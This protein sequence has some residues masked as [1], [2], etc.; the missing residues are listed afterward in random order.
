MAEAGNTG[1]SRI[2]GDLLLKELLVDWEVDKGEKVMGRLL[3][4]RRSVARQMNM[5]RYESSTEN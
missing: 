1:S 5:S 4:H 3:R 2:G